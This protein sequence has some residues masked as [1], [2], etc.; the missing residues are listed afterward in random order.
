MYIFF[1]KLLFQVF[2]LFYGLFVFFLIVGSLYILSDICTAN[3][4]PQC[5]ACLFIFLIMS[6]DHQKSFISVKF[7]NQFLLLW[8][9][10][11]VSYLRNFC[12]PLVSIFDGPQDLPEFQGL[13]RRTCSTPESCYTHGYSVLLPKDAD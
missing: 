9:V 6:F 10:H 13:P 2:Y 8:L 7:M 4:I 5:V 11:F 1:Y 12:L 3:I